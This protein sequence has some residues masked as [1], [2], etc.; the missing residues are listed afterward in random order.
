MKLKIEIDSDLPKEVILRAPSIDDEVVSVR[1]AIECALASSGEIA[2]K[3]AAGEIFVPFSEIFFFEA[4]SDKVYAH[5]KDD[6]LVCQ[7]TL[8]Q[9]SNLLPSTFCRASKSVIINTSKIRSMTR[10]ATGI[11]E[12]AFNGSEKTVY[13]SRMYYKAVREII[14][15][16]RLKK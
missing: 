15:E 14:E 16:T 12:A 11:G 1:R 9:L 3:S 4:S 10:Y 5:I 2:L 7:M 13:I 6:C 8:I